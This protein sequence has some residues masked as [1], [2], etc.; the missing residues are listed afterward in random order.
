[1][2]TSTHSPAPST[3]RVQVSELLFDEANPRLA[4]T[5]DAHTQ[6]S[7]FRTLWREFAVDELVS[8]IAANGFF[9][10][11]PL[12]AVREGGELIV[13]EGNRRLAALKALLHYLPVEQGVTLPKLNVTERKA[14]ESVPV[15]LT[16]REDIWQYVGFK[17]VNGPQVWQSASKARYIVHVHE[18]FG[19]TLEDIARR[20]G[21]K[22]STVQRLY[23]ASKVLDQA[24]SSGVFDVSDRWKRH[25]S[26]SHLYTGLDYAG[27]QNYLRVAPIAEPRR[28]PVPKDR[29]ENLGEVCVWLY[30][31][32]SRQK[33]PV[34]T[35]QN[36][37]LRILDEVIQTKDGL[38]ALRQ[39]LPLSVSR[40][41]GKGDH[42]ILRESLVSAK[43]YLQTARGKVLTGYSADDESDFVELAEDILDL[44][45]AI[46][47][48]LDRVR[49][50]AA[51]RRAETE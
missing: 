41:I 3:D 37:D 39:G 27:I 14:L 17:H 22:H 13:V 11:E 29:I 28:D 32:K 51:R 1:M 9:T 49:R 12:I 35:S 50:R 18:D 20:I 16:T 19:I 48:D 45:E 6:E 5:E 21:D 46:R 24:Q 38:A 47:E 23:R 36:P 4:E 15:V 26:F 44:A 40:E 25:F 33:V 30:G 2:P 8:S 34:V 7:I 43:S 31:S 10:H 42:R